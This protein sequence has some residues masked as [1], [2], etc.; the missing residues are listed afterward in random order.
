MTHVELEGIKAHVQARITFQM[1][2]CLQFYFNFEKMPNKSFNK[3]KYLTAVLL[4]L[5]NCCWIGCAQYPYNPWHLKNYQATRP[6][7]YNL[8][9]ALQ[10]GLPYLKKYWNK[11]DARLG[12]QKSNH[13]PNFAVN[14]PENC[15]DSSCLHL[16]FLGDIM[17]MRGFT[18]KLQSKTIANFLAQ[19]DLVLG[20]L[21]TPL[22]PKHEIKYL[23]PDYATYNDDTSLLACFTDSNK[24]SIING[25]S[26]ANNHAMDIGTEGLHA[27]IQFLKARG[28]VAMGANA[29]D[30]L[31]LYHVF[32]EKGI[33]IGVYAMGWG[34]NQP[35]D[36]N[37]KDLFF[38]LA[39]HLV[40][41]FDNNVNSYTAQK[42]LLQM[43]ADSMDLKIVLAHWGFEFE[44]FPDSIIRQEAR[45]LSKAG[46]D[47][48]IGTHP[49]V[50]QPWEYLK[51]DSHSNKLS[52]VYYSLGNF[53]SLM[54]TSACKNGLIAHI[55]VPIAKDKPLQA[56][57]LKPIFVYTA[58]KGFAG[59][60][61]KMYLVTDNW[62][63][64]PK[65]LSRYRFRNV[66]KSLNHLNL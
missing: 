52:I 31:A 29:N 40:H 41:P 2:D 34:L 39:P 5:T 3:V 37:N 17:W 65:W 47:I 58:K 64:Q 1:F 32:Y 16:A 10:Y 14:H 43:S 44:Y 35:S 30:S 42:A 19:Q 33:K 49:H 24:V 18:Q 50:V 7:G 59:R 61:T 13:T 12:F 8:K 28:I 25:L 66:R 6:E 57:A 15:L 62:Q 48:I 56:I 53:C 51:P 54:F 9:Q 36:L 27:T 55:A 4:V 26:L 63:Q 22:S 21:E 20:N 11:S 45:M 60:K 38:H 46:A 23:F